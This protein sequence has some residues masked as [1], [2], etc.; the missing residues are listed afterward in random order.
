[1]NVLLVTDDEA[2][3]IEVRRVLLRNGL[4]CPAS[5]I[6]RTEL[7]AQY[8]GKTPADLVVVVMPDDPERRPRRA[9]GA[10]RTCRGE[11]ECACWRWGRPPTPRSCL[12]ASG[13][14]SMITSTSPS[15]ST[16]MEAALSTVAVHPGEAGRRPGE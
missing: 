4:D 7:A 10:S 2:M 15:S 3:G 5:S 14:W 13:A 1:M 16:E 9:G 11:R 12:R 6:V 8:L